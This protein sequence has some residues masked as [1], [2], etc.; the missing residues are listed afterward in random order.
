MIKSPE[1]L[2]LTPW[3]Q[4]RKKKNGYIGKRKSYFLSVYNSGNGLSQESSN[5][6]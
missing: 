4:I 3:S 6:I 2:I 1:I 5:Q